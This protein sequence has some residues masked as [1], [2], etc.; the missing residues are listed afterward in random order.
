MAQSSSLES[1]R[2]VDDKLWKGII[3][4]LVGVSAERAQRLVFSNGGQPREYL[5]SK[6][7]APRLDS[8]RNVQRPGYGHGNRRE[9]CVA[10]P[11][12]HV[13][14]ALEPADRPRRHDPM[15]HHLR[16]NDCE[17]RTP[18]VSTLDEG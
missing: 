15:T 8:R 6:L 11:V 9:H 14:E 1:R 5:A 12:E 3:R 7:P 17:T 16:L 4:M 13:G 2:A 10:A 18:E